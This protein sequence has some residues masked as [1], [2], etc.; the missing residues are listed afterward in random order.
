[1][2]LAAC[3][4]LGLTAC[5]APAR[6]APDAD[7]VPC[8]LTERANAILV[9]LV[10][11]CGSADGRWRHDLGPGC[12]RI[13]AVRFGLTAGLRRGR[14]DLLELARVTAARQRTDARDLIVQAIFGA[15]DTDG[16]E[17]FGMP[18]LLASGMLDGDATGYTLFR[19][20][21]DRARGNLDPSTLRADQR[22]GLA[23]L[24]AELARAEPRAA[25][26]HL[27]DARR[28]A[29]DVGAPKLRALALAVIARVGGREDDMARARAAVE[30]A[31]PAMRFEEGRLQVEAQGD[32]ILSQELALVNALAELAVVARSDADRVRAQALLESVLTGPLWDGQLLAHDAELDGARSRDHCSGCNWNALYLVDRLW[33]DTWRIA[34]VPALPERGAGPEPPEVFEHD[35]Y[36]LRPDQRGTYG[37]RIFGL[38][39]EYAELAPGPEHPRGAVRVSWQLRDPRSRI[40]YVGD[41]VAELDEA[42]AARL[43]LGGPF[44]PP[45]AHVTATLGPRRDGL[46]HLRVVE[47]RR[48][49]D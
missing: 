24:T 40:A 7:L 48:S 11:D 41:P 36:L 3:I 16:P 14:D 26:R 2:R 1:M 44:G 45:G 35:L 38:E 34:A 27:D 13:W 43:R 33:G 19:L 20:A 9:R 6:L 42:G 49:A 39:L 17:A 21:F 15:S 28:I 8:P 12:P 46:R 23:V 22:A 30:A 32:L 4:L 29:E 47:E 31:L 10:E 37:L 25:G 18:A 5:R